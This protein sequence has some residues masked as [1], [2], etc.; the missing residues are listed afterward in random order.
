M[1]QKSDAEFL[2]GLR[3][4]LAS[5]NAEK[6]ILDTKIQ[7]LR[8]A[9]MA[10]SSFVEQPEIDPAKGLTEGIKSAMRIVQPHG[11]YPTTLRIKL[12]EAGFVFTGINPLASIHSILQR[13]KK[14]HLVATLVR[15]GK[16]AYYWCGSPDETPSD[17]AKTFF[18]GE[19]PEDLVL[20][21]LERMR[22][23]SETQTA[24]RK[25]RED[26]GKKKK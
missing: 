1:A 5:A 12:E 16:I 21:P 8:R 24:K 25:E 7:R 19:V 2:E 14:K 20:T 13:L 15:E 3:R 22:R 6:L 4:Q 17:Y 11:L 26:R 23:D 10:V 18:S 9:I